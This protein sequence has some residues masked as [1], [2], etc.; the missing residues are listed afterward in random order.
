MYYNL[1]IAWR[2]HSFI[3]EGLCFFTLVTILLGLC[4]T[5]HQTNIWQNLNLLW[6]MM[7]FSTLLGIDG[8]F[9]DDKHDGTLETLLLHPYSVLLRYIYK[10]LMIHFLF[11]ISPI[12]LIYVPLGLLLHLP[13][14]LLIFSLSIFTI[15][16]QGLLCLASFSSALNLKRLNSNFLRFLIILPLSTPLW[17]FAFSAIE[18]FTHK[19]GISSSSLFF[20]VALCLFFTLIGPIFCSLILLNDQ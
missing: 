6:L 9:E 19:Y 7:L 17:L 10:K 12:L 5:N 13:V 2:K 11:K 4:Q 14:N 15:A 8:L 18:N 3:D 1:L 16:V 20:L